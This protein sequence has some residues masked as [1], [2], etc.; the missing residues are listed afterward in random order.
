MK[1]RIVYIAIVSTFISCK[2]D[3]TCTCTLTSGGATIKETIIY[4]KVSNKTAKTDCT[5]QP[6]TVDDGN[7][8]VVTLSQTCVLN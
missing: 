7:G 8:N 5:T 1:K 2:K 4:H 3:R 6:I